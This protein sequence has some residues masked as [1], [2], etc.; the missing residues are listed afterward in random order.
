MNKR[1]SP[2]TSRLKTT[3]ER[4]GR[5]EG[6]LTS[7]AEAQGRT[8]ERMGRMEGALTA[9][10][11]AQGRTDKQIGRL[12]E[13]QGRTEEQV[14]S[15]VKA[16]NRTEESVRQLAHT[17]GIF[18]DTIGFGLEDIAHVVLPGY[19]QR[20]LGM[21]LFGDELERRFITTD[22]RVIEV[23]LYGKGT[24]NGERVI[25]IGECKSRIRSSQVEDF[26]AIVEQL[27]PH[28]EERLLPVMFGYWIHPS[29]MEA[30]KKSGMLLVASYQ[31]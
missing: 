7:L 5:L 23:N 27:R 22:Q 26:A 2:S 14:A 6:A 15:L 11:E 10:T 18:S 24:Q 28:F 20:H 25:V 30:A 19:L 3:T 9:L 31:K 1:K 12:V 17:A 8:E 16:Q 29:A 21:K 13:A 4:M